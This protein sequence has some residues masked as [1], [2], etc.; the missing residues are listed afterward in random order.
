MHTRY[1][2]ASRYHAH[3]YAYETC[4]GGAESAGQTESADEATGPGG[5]ARRQRH[6]PRGR[7]ARDTRSAG[8]GGV[9]DGPTGPHRTDR[10]RTEAAGRS[11]ACA[12][13]PR[14]GGG[15]EVRPSAHQRGDP[16][17]ALG[18]RR[19]RPP[20]AGRGAADRP[21]GPGSRLAV[22]DR[23]HQTVRRALHP[24]ARHRA[25]GVRPEARRRL[26][27]AARAGSDHRRPWPSHPGTTGGLRGSSLSRAVPPAPLRKRGSRVVPG[28]VRRAW[29]A[30]GSDRSWRWRR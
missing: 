15:D 8:A 5:R 24:R 28:R 4:P 27:P 7:P 30:A 14:A 16:R 26:H 1:I 20:S 3:A 25:R 29:R 18:H 13:R 22:P 23:A 9:H 6:H 11:E 2:S 12:R 10:R 21:R 19:D 17:N